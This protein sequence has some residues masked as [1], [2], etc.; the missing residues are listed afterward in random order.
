MTKRKTMNNLSDWTELF[1]MVY[2]FA[3]IGIA[4]FT[5]DS[6]KM[7]TRLLY[8]MLSLGIFIIIIAFKKFNY[9]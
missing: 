3:M 9:L 7:I 6:L 2:G 4:I 8:G 1:F 5:E